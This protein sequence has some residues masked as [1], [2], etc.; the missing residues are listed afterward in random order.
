M[1]K[2]KLAIR[3]FLGRRISALAVAAVALC[4][5]IVVVVMTVMNGLVV[6]FKEK[7]HRFAADCVI[8][9]DSL[10][11]FP[12]YAEFVEE[13]NKVEFVEATS[14]VINSFGLLTKP[15]ADWNIGVEISGVNAA[16]HI[17][18]TGFGDTLHYHNLSPKDAFVPAYNPNLNGCVVGVDMM[19]RGRNRAGEYYYEPNPPQIELMISCFPLTAKG[20]LAKAGTDLVNT[21]NFFFSDNSHSGLVKVDGNMIYIPFDKA[22]IMCGMAGPTPRASAIHIKFT[23]KI[24][25]HEGCSK[26][27]KMWKDFLRTKKDDNYQSLLA[28]VN[29]QSWIENRKSTIAPMEKEQTMLIML[30]LMLGIITVFV[31]FVVFYMIISH[32]SKD[33][34]ILRSIGVPG[35]GVVELFVYFAVIVGIVGSTIG[36]SAGCAFLFKANEIENWLFMK[37]GWQVWDRSVYAIGEIPNDIEMNVLAIIMASAVAASVLGALLPAV[38]AAAKK[39]AEALQVNQL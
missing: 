33:I 18:T 20:A 30:F 2:L 26:V 17:R 25:L 4:V 10:V 11:G 39:P 34:G 3:Y 15:G 19:E 23:D 7:N 24:S 14:S 5:F 35:L 38:Q 9:T 29:V 13:L 31:I 16:D 37:Y 12:Y 32:K 36:A 1:Y 22:Q 28:N 8:S 27:Q 6:E 21:M